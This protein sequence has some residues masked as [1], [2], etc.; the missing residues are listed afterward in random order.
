MEKAG[1]VNQR[2]YRNVASGT[3]RKRPESDAD[4]LRSESRFNDRIKTREAVPTVLDLFREKKQD[5]K[6]EDSGCGPDIRV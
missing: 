4:W 2:R 3:G 5:L 1:S 6:L